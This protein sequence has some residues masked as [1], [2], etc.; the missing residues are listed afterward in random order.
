MKCGATFYHG[1]GVHIRCIKDNPHIGLHDNG[2]GQ[3]WDDESLSV[4]KGPP[5][6]TVN[7]SYTEI[8][9]TVYGRMLVPTYDINQTGSLRSEML[10]CDHNEIEM[11]RGLL[12]H[13]IGY[14]TFIDVGANIGTFSLGLH[15][16]FDSVH[17]FEPQRIIYNMLCGTVALNGIENIYCHNVALSSEFGK[18]SAPK[19]DYS[20]PCNFGSIEFGGKQAEQ[21]EQQPQKSNETV[22]MRTLDSYY[23]LEPSLIKIDAEGMD[24]R[25][26]YGA[27]R[28]I[29]QSRPIVFVETL[30][31]DPEPLRHF[32]MGLGYELRQFEAN[33]LYIP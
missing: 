2:F 29:Q 26:I 12:F 18:L 30:K 1:N 10:P 3:R 27:S 22:I 32:M 31:I 15:N 14:K 6:F 4:A 20:K 23:D 5:M 17:A 25:V 33:D 28:M 16:R 8:L 21:L 11:L 19:F 9:D 24:D 13:T 7:V